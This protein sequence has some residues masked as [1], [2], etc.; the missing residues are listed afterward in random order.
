MIKNAE[1][2]IAKNPSRGNDVGTAGVAINEDQRKANDARKD[3]AKFQC[4]FLLNNGAYQV[5]CIVS[6][7]DEEF[8]GEDGICC[9][10]DMSLLDVFGGR[11]GDG[12]SGVESI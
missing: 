10:S 11:H 8:D 4:K 1:D 5:Q 9:D 12:G 6:S 2:E 3:F 7:G